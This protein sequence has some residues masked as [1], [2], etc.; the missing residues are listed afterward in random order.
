MRPRF[1]PPTRIVLIRGGCLL[2]AQ[3]WRY[4]PLTVPTTGRKWASTPASVASVW[5][6]TARKNFPGKSEVGILAESG[7]DDGNYFNYLICRFGRLLRI[8]PGLSSGSIPVG[9]DFLARHDLPGDEDVTRPKLLFSEPLLGARSH[10]LARGVG[11]AVMRFSV[12][13]G[14]AKNKA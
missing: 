12:C 5:L 7:R 3:M 1:V 13:S 14:H 11:L 9:V 10:I 2:P 4:G 8:G 6:A